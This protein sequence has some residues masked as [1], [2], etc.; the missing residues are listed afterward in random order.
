MPQR[1]PLAGACLQKCLSKQGCS[2]FLLLPHGGTDSVTLPLA[3]ISLVEAV[4]LASTHC[5][6]ALGSHHAW[7]LVV[8]PVAHSHRFCPDLAAVLLTLEP[9]LCWQPLGCS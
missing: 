8:F 9:P 7:G 2:S 4:V 5:P 6:P 1:S 3:C